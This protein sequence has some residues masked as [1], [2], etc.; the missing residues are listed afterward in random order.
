M[1]FPL[2][3]VSGRREAKGR[4]RSM[5]LKLNSSDAETTLLDTGSDLAEET[6]E[7]SSVSNATGGEGGSD[8]V[9]D[10]SGSDG[11]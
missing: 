11:K 9:D 3:K 1:D 4:R 5:F 10:G 6:A 2:L 8:N 7:E